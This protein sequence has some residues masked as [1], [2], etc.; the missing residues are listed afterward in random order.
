[1]TVALFEDSRPSK[2]G[3]WVDGWYRWAAANLIHFVCVFGEIF[4]LKARYA[5]ALRAAATR[6]AA[7]S[8]TQSYS[9][10]LSATRAVGGV[11]KPW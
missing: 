1:M 3:G 11:L 8:L 6:H 10:L 9:V 5:R 7:R 2:V 4:F